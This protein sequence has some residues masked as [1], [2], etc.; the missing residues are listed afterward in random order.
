MD[1]IS[2][3]VYLL[4][5]VIII[6]LNKM[7]RKTAVDAITSQ[8]TEWDDI[9]CPICMEHPHN[10]IIL[11]CSS[12]KKGC[13]SY[14]CD[15]S[16]LHSNCLDRFVE[17]SGG[18]KSRHSS[19]SSSDYGN[20][21][22]ELSGTSLA[23]SDR[24][25][26]VL[27]DTNDNLNLNGNDTVVSRGTRDNNLIQDIHL[28][29]EQSSEPDITEASWLRIASEVYNSGFSCQPD[30]SITCPMCRGKV[31]GWEI[32][33]EERKHLNLLKRGCSHDGC[34]FS[35]N[36]RELRCHARNDHFGAN[37]ISVDPTRERSWHRL[38]QQRERDDIITALHSEAPDAVVV[39]DYVIERDGRQLDEDFDADR[40]W[41]D[42]LYILH[43]INSIEPE[44]SR[45]SRP[46][47]RHRRLV[48]APSERNQ[49][50]WGENLLGLQDD[51][52]DTELQDNANGNLSNNVD[53]DLSPARRR[54]RNLTGF[55]SE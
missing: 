23:V 16:Y 21:S 54:R 14:I 55:S 48:A 51:E 28:P 9:V 40:Q 30:M 2:C 15:T 22:A 19:L 20:N 12:Y 24:I 6:L 18:P 29:G 52:D 38:E 32:A 44:S 4:W 53:G 41:L 3:L 27:S 25:G 17:Q 34:S 13:R 37:P 1:R 46:W 50:L 33:V 43:M 49:L 31:T 7:K 11:R 10:A 36:Y 8:T 42:T 35:G 39:G 26:F 5:N 47:S 45:R